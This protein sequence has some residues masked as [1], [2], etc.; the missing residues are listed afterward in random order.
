MGYLGLLTAMLHVAIMGYSNWF[1][2]D[3]WPGY[4]P[5]ITLIGFVIAAIP[6]Y[7]KYLKR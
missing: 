5:P 3:T 6:L 1:K 7:F 4:L 2:V